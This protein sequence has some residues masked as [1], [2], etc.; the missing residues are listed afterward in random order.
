VYVVIRMKK[1]ELS[2]FGFTTEPNV[3][4]APALGLPVFDPFLTLSEPAVPVSTI[5]VPPDPSPVVE[6]SVE[7]ASENPEGGLE[8]VPDAVVQA[9]NSIAWMV[10]AVGAVKVNAYV[11]LAL[12]AELPITTFRA[13]I[14]E[15]DACVDCTIGATMSA[16][17]LKKYATLLNIAFVFIILFLSTELTNSYI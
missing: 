3:T 5:Q 8:Q 11:V 10:D 2:A 4:V 7:D 17:A 13:V 6:L 12:G 1:V 16:S 14:C 9:L 15:A